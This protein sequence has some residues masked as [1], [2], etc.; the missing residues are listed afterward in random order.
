MRT[1]EDSM[2]K[3]LT[4]T[5]KR[6]LWQMAALM[7]AAGVIAIGVNH[8]RADGIVL[9]G[10]WS[11]QARFADAEG[12]SLVIE[13]AQARQ[14]FE[15]GEAVFVDARPPYQY[16]QGHI[17]G[18]LN[19]P[20]QEIDRYFLEVADDLDDQKII[21]TYCDGEACDLSHELALF[22]RDM[23]FGTASVLVNGWTI[24]QQAGL[25]TEDR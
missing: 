11:A 25:P 15:Q 7:A 5:L 6:S 10:D 24:W 23:G 20:W 9:V 8:F 3:Q 1:W 17:Q 22:L 12:R 13:L 4:I 2:I 21:I 19:L 16:A 14:L 18:A